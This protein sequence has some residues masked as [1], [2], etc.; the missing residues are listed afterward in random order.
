MAEDGSQLWRTT[1]Q[2]IYADACRPDFDLVRPGG[3]YCAIISLNDMRQAG[4]PER[5]GD[6][7]EA[8]R[9]EHRINLA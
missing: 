5:T 2:A 1:E 8:F 6:D 7:G 9:R 3:R 4:G